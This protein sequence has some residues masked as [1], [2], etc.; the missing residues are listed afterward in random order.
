[1]WLKVSEVLSPVSSKARE[2]SS[3]RWTAGGITTALPSML[4]LQ[5]THP[6]LGAHN[7]VD[8]G[9]LD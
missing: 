5:S 7:R 6:G 9:S 8:G 1:M 4:G 3:A 2:G